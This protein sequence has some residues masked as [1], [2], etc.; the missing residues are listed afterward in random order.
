MRCITGKSINLVPLQV[1][2]IPFDV[3]FVNFDDPEVLGRFTGPDYKKYWSE[4]YGFDF[5]TKLQAERVTVGNNTYMDTDV[6]QLAK[7]CL[8]SE[9]R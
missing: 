4:T 7:Y 6:L 9:F 8:E 3:D 5:V 1:G 2:T